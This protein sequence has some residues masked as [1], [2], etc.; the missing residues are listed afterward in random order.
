[1]ITCYT[2]GFFFSSSSSY[3]T[4]EPPP[5]DEEGRNPDAKTK[6]EESEQGRA[7][8]AAAA[9]ERAGAE[10]NIG[11]AE[12]CHD[13]GALSRQTAVTTANVDTLQ[14]SNQ[15]EFSCL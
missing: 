8:A 9:A 1:M 11:I 13:K 3:F 15:G 6:A 12:R 10:R 14:P 4:G 5:S 2:F 7:A